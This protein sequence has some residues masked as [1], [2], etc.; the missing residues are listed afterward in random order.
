MTARVS[1][2]IELDSFDLSRAFREA[3]D[4]IAAVY[5]DNKDRPWTTIVELKRAYF[6]DCMDEGRG[7]FCFEFSG[8]DELD[9]LREE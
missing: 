3:A 1:A 5:E 6:R 4:K 9:S 7:G 2:M 8:Y